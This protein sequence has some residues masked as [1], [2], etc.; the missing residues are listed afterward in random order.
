L[1]WRH[2]FS[3]PRNGNIT[4]EPIFPV[5]GGSRGGGGGGEEG[6]GGGERGMVVCHS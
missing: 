3:S 1:R 2:E 6:A 5:L 4:W